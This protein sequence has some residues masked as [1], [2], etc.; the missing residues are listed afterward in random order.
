[1]HMADALISTPVAVATGA[2]AA[3]LIGV[4][5]RKASHS[6]REGIVSLMGVMG[7]FVFA[8]QMINFTIPGTGSSGHIIGGIL[9]SALLGPW[10]AFLT[11]TSVLIVQCLIFADGGLL[12]LGCNIINMGAMSCLIAYPLVYK[13]IVNR[14]YTP[15]RLIT[16]SVAASIAGLELGA[17]CVTIETTASGITALNFGS[18][19]GIMLAIHLAI[20]AIE[21]IATGLI[22]VFV[23]RNSP[24]MLNGTDYENSKRNKRKTLIV[25]GSI[26]LIFAITFVWIA[27]G[28]PDGL[29]WSIEKMTGATELA[30]AQTP[31][32]AFMPDY[33]SHLSGIVGGIIV[34]ITLW[35]LSSLLL[36]RTKRTAKKIR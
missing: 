4:A 33:E 15:A 22:L 1:M 16:A 7:A 10:C 27:S 24:E 18:F 6:S 25:I 5:S 11:L 13:P 32:T 35:A 14:H 23:L 20:G 19:L 21:G 12:A 8:A 36:N 3:A 28:N 30:P 26:A 17:L 34:M 31:A 9:L 2:A 29:E